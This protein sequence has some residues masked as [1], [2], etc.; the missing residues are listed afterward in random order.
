MSK[1]IP[2]LIGAMLLGLVAVAWASS[3][4]VG[5]PRPAK[6]PVS[7]REDSVKGTHS[8]TRYRH[9]RYFVGGGRFHGK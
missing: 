5:V 9:S 3:R 6:K 2:V 4:G 7:I 8:G 1:G